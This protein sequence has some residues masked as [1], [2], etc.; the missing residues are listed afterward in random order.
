MVR[1]LLWVAAALSLADFTSPPAQAS[2]SDDTAFLFRCSD[3]LGNGVFNVPAQ[4]ATSDDDAAPDFGLSSGE[5]VFE[6][7]GGPTEAAPF[8]SGGSVEPIG[9]VAAHCRDGQP[10]TA[11][12]SRA[13]PHRA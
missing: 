2:R 3:A 11:F 10:C 8:L 7:D 13:P 1:L 4:V 6:G 12:N 9:I 5:P